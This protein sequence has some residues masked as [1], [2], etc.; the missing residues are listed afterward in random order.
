MTKTFPIGYFLK[1]KSKNLSDKHKSIV[2]TRFSAAGRSKKPR[3]NLKRS[4]MAASTGLESMDTTEADTAKNKR[5]VREEDVEHISSKKAR[6]ETGNLGAQATEPPELQQGK[7]KVFY[8]SAS[9]CP[10]WVYLESSERNI[11][12]LHV[13]SVVKKL[14]SINANTFA[15]IRESGKNRVKVR[16]DLYSEANNLVNNP[17]LQALKLNAFIPYNAVMT[18]GVIKNVDTELSD[19]ELYALIETPDKIKLFDIRRMAK[20]D[21]T[22][23]PVVV[24]TFEGNQLP[25]YVNILQIR[26]KVE[27]YI[28]RPLR[29]HKCQH[30]GHIKNNCKAALRCPLCGGEHGEDQC[31]KPNDL[32]CILCGGRHKTTDKRCPKF[33]EEKQIKKIMVEEKITFAEARAALKTTPRKKDQAEE[34]PFCLNKPDFPA[35]QTQVNNDSLSLET[36]DSHQEGFWQTPRPARQNQNK[37]KSQTNHPVHPKAAVPSK[38]AFYR[39][40]ESN[41]IS[42]TL[43]ARRNNDNNTDKQKTKDLNSWPDW[44]KK[45]FDRVIEFISKTDSFMLKLFSTPAE[46]LTG[47]IRY[48]LNTVEK[49]EN[50]KHQD[51]C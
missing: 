11:Q 35:L 33:Q 27:M 21:K 39:Y 41:N 13:M 15:E 8:S 38:D 45:L 2:K 44:V 10:F 31:D 42:Q 20:S 32:Q 47:L 40:T 3:P 29:C 5:D 17:G 1:S 51:G 43:F 18:Q 23:I 6:N 50:N 26:C 28:P 19:E 49:S 30:F 46:I 9:K 7:K 12:R 16:Y 48:C 25:A 36:L 24:L 22:P 37:G 4:D 34:I 14:K